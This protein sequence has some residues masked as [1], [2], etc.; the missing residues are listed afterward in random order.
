MRAHQP[1]RAVDRS[2]PLQGADEHAE[3]G[4]VRKSTRLR[5]TTT[6]RAP[7]STSSTSFSRSRGAVYTSTSPPTSSTCGRR[8]R[9]STT[10]APCG[11]PP[12][13]GSGLHS[14]FRGLSPQRVSRASNHRRPHK[15]TRPPC[16]P[17][18][19]HV[20][21]T[22]S[23]NICLRVLHVTAVLPLFSFLPARRAESLTH[24]E[25][26]PPRS[27]GCLSL[28]GLDPAPAQGRFHRPR[29]G[30]S[31]G[32][33]RSSRGRS[34]RG[35][36]PHRHR[37]RDGLRKVPRLPAAFPVRRLLGPT[38]R[39][40]CSTSRR[41]R[42]WPPTSSARCTASALPGVRPATY[43]GDTPREER[44][45]VRAAREVVLTNPD[46]LHHGILPGHARGPASCAACASWSSTSA[47]RYRGVFG[48]HVAQVLRRLRRVAAR[49]GARPALHPGVGDRRRPAGVRRRR[50]TGC[51]WRR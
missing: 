22:I 34:L 21:R 37:H 5:S 16:F 26:V 2:Q 1:E 51:R 29:R 30:T 35:P 18:M 8:S 3:P 36:A 41:P 7:A 44:D 9:T 27:G 43:D 45:W 46:M 13:G 31:P 40:R 50:L 32:P 24:I 6:W 4:R 10:T 38:T 48:S 39:R 28:A 42:P 23:S 17:Q 19:P 15:A 33:T 11:P 25:H 49:Y 12:L 14:S 47:T 20:Y